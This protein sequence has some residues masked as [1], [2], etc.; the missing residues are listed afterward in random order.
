MQREKK[1]LEA[2]WDDFVDTKQRERKLKHRMG[3]EWE[4]LEDFGY[5]GNN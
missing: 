1:R 4:V 3:A 5:P 2:Q